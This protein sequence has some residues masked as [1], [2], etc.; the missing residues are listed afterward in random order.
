VCNYSKMIGILY[1][2]SKRNNGMKSHLHLT[3]G[4]DLTFMSILIYRFPLEGLDKTPIRWLINITSKYS[5]V[6][7]ENI[8]LVSTSNKYFEGLID[9]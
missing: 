5:W 1:D 2:I 8:I 4:F 9:N 3:I 6:S 7:L